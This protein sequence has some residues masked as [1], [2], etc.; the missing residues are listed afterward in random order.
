MD[1]TSLEW[2]GAAASLGMWALFLLGMLWL[3][4]QRRS[5][6]R[7]LKAT[8]DGPADAPYRVF[9]RTHDAELTAADIP[10]RLRELSPLQ[11]SHY[12]KAELWAAHRNHLQRFEAERTPT[13]EIIQ[14]LRDAIADPAGLAVCFLI[15][16]SGSMKGAPIAAAAS[17]V[18][19]VS[20]ALVALGAT[21]EIL[22]F[23]TAG[24]QGGF[25]RQQWLRQGRPERPG[26]LCALAHIVYKRADETEWA[27]DSRAAFLH[28]DVL[29]ENVDGEALEWAETRLASLPCPHK[30]LIVL[31]DGA[32]VDDSTLQENGPSY[33][34]RHL[35][36]TIARIEQRDDL[37]LG[38]VGIEHAVDEWYR[39]SRAA[40]VNTLTGALID[41]VATLG[42]VPP[43][44]S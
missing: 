7:G 3:L 12:A 37:L 2:Q 40:N 35:R 14:G 16:Q 9:T 17:A 22:G 20:D 41:L 4:W 6:R 19:A 34:V 10:G 39:H 11:P 8:K 38:A 43:P 29:R 15:D 33:L 5:A 26:R 24:W 44:L 27:A 32:P 36:A 25:P 1:S 30:L 42:R 21:T 28:P 23:S 13:N 18:G 31:S